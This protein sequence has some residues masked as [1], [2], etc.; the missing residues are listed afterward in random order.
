MSC[1]P[2][3]PWRHLSPPLLP[4][5]RHC[6]PWRRDG[7]ERYLPLP[8]LP[9]LTQHTAWV[10]VDGCRRLCPWFQYKILT[11]APAFIPDGPARHP[12]LNRTDEQRRDTRSPGSDPKHAQPLHP[13]ASTPPAIRST[14]CHIDHALPL[15]E[16]EI[17]E[18]VFVTFQSY[19]ILN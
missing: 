13:A 19:F 12:S 5:L 7:P 15:P 2:G 4:L 9:S 3:N 14:P 1:T 18:R 8:L 10:M 17:I 11:T 16:S 6:Y